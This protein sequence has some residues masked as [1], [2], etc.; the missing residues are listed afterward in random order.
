MDQAC[1]GPGYATSEEPGETGSGSRAR[2]R[3]EQPQKDVNRKDASEPPDQQTSATRDE[4]RRKKNEENEE[5][6]CG[7][8]AAIMTRKDLDHNRPN[9]NCYNFLYGFKGAPPARHA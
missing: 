3:D 4:P 1:N 9:R 8:H 7:N 6:R 2:Y 5:D